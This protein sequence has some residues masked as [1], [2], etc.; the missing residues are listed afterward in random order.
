MSFQN[1]SFHC[2][3][4]YLQTTQLEHNTLMLF[5][6]IYGIMMHLVDWYI[7]WS[8]T[9]GYA[10]WLIWTVTM[11]VPLQVLWLLLYSSTILVILLCKWLCT[12]VSPLCVERHIFAWV[13][14]HSRAV[15]KQSRQVEMAS[16][17]STQGQSSCGAFIHIG[18]SKSSDHHIKVIHYSFIL[19]TSVCHVNLCR[20]WYAQKLGQEY[21]LYC[22]I[23]N[24]LGVAKEDLSDYLAAFLHSLPSLS[25]KPLTWSMILLPGTSGW[26][27]IIC[28]SQHK[29]HSLLFLPFLFL[30]LLYLSGLSVGSDLPEFCTSLEDSTFTASAWRVTGNWTA[31]V[32]MSLIEVTLQIYYRRCNMTKKEDQKWKFAMIRRRK[33]NSSMYWRRLSSFL[34]RFVGWGRNNLKYVLP[35]WTF[36]GEWD[37]HSLAFH[38]QRSQKCLEDPC[39]RKWWQQPWYFRW[40]AHKETIES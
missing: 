21:V 2:M 29:V 37:C 3:A 26:G 13:L 14:W 27:M 12:W 40:D 5:I 36:D 31:S 25:S 28:G 7:T 11:W 35:H 32:I 22:A 18:F 30:R 9:F 17:H 33:R 34:Q 1:H 15:S 16:F 10:M 20:L 6:P 39:Y 4:L 24:G 38:R 8:D 23:G 19:W